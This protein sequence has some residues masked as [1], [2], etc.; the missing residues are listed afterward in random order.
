M[1]TRPSPTK[2]AAE[3]RNENCCARSNDR[4]GEDR[5]FRRQ[6]TH[7]LR[8]HGVAPTWVYSPQPPQRKWSRPQRAH[9]YRFG[10]AATA[11]GEWHRTQMMERSPL[12]HDDGWSRPQRS[13]RHVLRCSAT[14]RMPWH[15]SHFANA[16]AILQLVQSNRPSVRRTCCVVLQTGQTT[17]TTSR[18]SP[19]CGGLPAG[20]LRV[21]VS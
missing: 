15:P 11:V 10:P 9:R 12:A 4:S 18:S 2:Q 7:R 3:K 6:L 19:T 16:H 8:H 5:R 21:F 14:C 20:R 1:R 17:G 13:H